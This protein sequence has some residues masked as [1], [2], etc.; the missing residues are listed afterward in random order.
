M[1]QRIRSERALMT[2]TE[3]CKLSGFSRQHIHRLLR[4]DLL[5]GVKLVHDWLV[6]EDSLVAYLAQPRK[7]GPK[8]PHQSS[9]PGQDETPS[10]ENREV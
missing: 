3:A 4:G 2:T 6:Y 8:G 5:E 1:S 9:A 7:R 10:A